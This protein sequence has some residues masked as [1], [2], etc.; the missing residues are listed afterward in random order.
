M[1][2]DGIAHEKLLADDADAFA[3]I[4]ELLLK[5]SDKFAGPIK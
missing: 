3:L 1:Y 4:R 2:R 5:P